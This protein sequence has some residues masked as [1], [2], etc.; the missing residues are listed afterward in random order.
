M[1]ADLPEQSS[2][3]FEPLPPISESASPSPAV[4]LPVEIAGQIAD[5]EVTWEQTAEGGVTLPVEII[6]A[7]YDLYRVCWHQVGTFDPGRELISDG[8][9]LTGIAGLID[10]DDAE[11]MDKACEAV[12]PHEEL[13]SRLAG[14]WE[15]AEQPEAAP[16]HACPRCGKAIT[17][18]RGEVVEE[19]ANPGGWREAW[20]M[21]TT[22]LPCGCTK[23][24]DVRPC[25]DA[26]QPEG[27]A[28]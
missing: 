18:A 14:P 11:A 1:T 10:F 5:H 19:G 24:T 26:E 7:L 15:P 28:R 2:A 9:K 8:V 13:L 12:E 4:T 21:A 3:G 27:G 22:Y 6:R 25:D 23:I 16:K 17:E 20:K